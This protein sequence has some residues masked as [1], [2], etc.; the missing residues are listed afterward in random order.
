MVKKPTKQNFISDLLDWGEDKMKNR[1]QKN[2]EQENWPEAQ[3]CCRNSKERQQADMPYESV[4][5]IGGH[6]RERL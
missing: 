1:V 6:I 2:Q 4:K 5:E 3:V